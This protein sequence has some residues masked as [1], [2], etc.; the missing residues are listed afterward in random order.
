[1]VSADWMRPIGRTRTYLF[2]KSALE[3]PLMVNSTHH[4]RLE[5]IF[6]TKESRKRFTFPMIM[7]TIS[8]RPFK[9]VIIELGHFSRHTL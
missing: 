5:M 4:F 9:Q 3:L 6:V 7:P 8:A 2:L 1:M